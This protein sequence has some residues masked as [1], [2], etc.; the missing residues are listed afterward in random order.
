MV[1]EFYPPSDRLEIAIRRAYKRFVA[2]PSR[3][4]WEDV[5]KLIAKRSPETVERMER[6]MGLL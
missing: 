1:I 6:K 2:E 4:K 3:E 5:T